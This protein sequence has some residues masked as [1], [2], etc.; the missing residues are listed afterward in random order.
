MQKER[1]YDMQFPE[2]EI[3]IKDNRKIRRM[4]QFRR[5]KV[6]IGGDTLLSNDVIVSKH[7]QTSKKKGCGK[8]KS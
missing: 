8:K 7:R 3:Y 6:E 4:H 2:E 1:K 5:C